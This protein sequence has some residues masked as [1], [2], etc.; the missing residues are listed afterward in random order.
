MASESFCPL[1]WVHQAT[2]TDGSALL[3]CVAENASGQNLNRTS[4]RE[5]WNSKHWKK[6]RQQMMN[7]EKP[8]ACKRCWVE[9]G[10]G[11]RSHRQTELGV[12][13]ARLGVDALEKML[14]ETEADGSFQTPPKSIDLRLG[15]TCNLQCVM[16]RPHDSSKWIGLA[17]KMSLTAESPAIRDDL[18]YKLKLKSDDFNWQE[19]AE[20]WDELVEFLPDLR[21]LIIGG[22][23]PMLLEQHFRF[24][25]RCVSSGHAE[26]IQLRYHTNLTVLPAEVLPLWQKFKF[27]E[28][29][30][31]IDALGDMNHYVRH[32]AKWQDIER[33]LRLLDTMNFE[34]VRTMILSSVHFLTFFDLDQLLGWIQEQKFKT[35]THGY[36]G[37]I[38]PGI[39]MSPEYLSVQAYP[40]ALKKAI[41][42][43][44][45]AFEAGSHKRS[46]KIQGVLNYMMERDQ[47][48]RLPA[49]MDYIRQLD[50]ARG[51][52]F[53]STFLELCTALTAAGVLA[54]DKSDFLNV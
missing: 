43:K 39:V 46:N 51:T 30:A 33:H 27:V 29:F 15:N 36:N 7:G 26:H 4:F 45:T 14:S 34:K 11:Y 2:Y 28:V 44:I 38:H 31:S 53:R 16:C 40:V 41:A 21:E 54:R 18:S 49:T 3:C 9:E 47:T 52:N 35:V 8:A 24:L 48:S 10:N 37:H 32:P 50:T 19:R 22:G 23:E 13:Q 1:P 42:T 17:K 12:W 6:V 5:S 20:I 25:E